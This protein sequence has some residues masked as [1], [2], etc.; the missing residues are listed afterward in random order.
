MKRYCEDYKDAPR[1]IERILKWTGYQVRVKREAGFS[2]PWD[3]ERPYDH[4]RY[5]VS[6]K[7]P[8]G[9]LTRFYFWGSRDEYQKNG[10]CD[11]WEMIGSWVRDS[12]YG[13]MSFEDCCS[14]LG[15]NPD[16]IAALKMW[17]SCCRVLAA[18][19]RIFPERIKEALMH[20]A[21]QM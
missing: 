9:A 7:A 21:Y 13:E 6:I 1:C 12:E 5:R 17:K 8:G 2:C 19:N 10:T 4:F 3:K 20:C 18:C 16:S 11:T 15:E 14:E